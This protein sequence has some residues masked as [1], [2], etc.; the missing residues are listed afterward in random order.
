VGVLSTSA[1]TQKRPSRFPY[2]ATVSPVLLAA[3]DRLSDAYGGL[4]M[5]VARVEAR[6][7]QELAEEAAGAQGGWGVS[8]LTEG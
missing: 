6:I 4:C 2:Y 7:A 8:N 1:I 3:H 5:A